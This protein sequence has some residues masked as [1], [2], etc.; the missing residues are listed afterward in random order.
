MLV[1]YTYIYTYIQATRDETCAKWNPKAPIFYSYRDDCDDAD[2]IV[3]KY[4]AWYGWQKPCV[5]SSGEHG[6]DREVIQVWYSKSKNTITKVKY[7]QHNGWYIMTP[8]DGLQMSGDRP[9]IHVGKIA[10]GAYHTGCT[11]T[12]NAG[13]TSNC[14][15]GCGYW[16]DQRDSSDNKYVLTD[17]T[18]INKKDLVGAPV[19]DYDT[20]CTPGQNAWRSTKSAACFAVRDKAM[21]CWVDSVCPSAYP[22][23]DNAFGVEGTCIQ[24]KDIGASC[25]YGSTCKSG[26]CM[27]M[28]GIDGSCQCSPCTSSGCGGCPSGESCHNLSIYEDNVCIKIGIKFGN[29]SVCTN[30]AMCKSNC[31]SFTTVGANTCKSDAWYRTCT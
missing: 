17:S 14:A 25:T 13:S 29:G 24:K 6:D 20:W 5:G 15:G 23:C 12:A 31:C 30:S 2:K 27:A 10:H 11:L 4:T 1:S 26:D 21:T 8:A 7:H 18:L 16:E 3:I 9:V 19:C 22:V 28:G